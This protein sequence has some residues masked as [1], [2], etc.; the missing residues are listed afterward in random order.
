MDNRSNS[1]DADNRSV[2]GNHI[3]LIDKDASD[4]AT[5]NVTEECATEA[6][7]GRHPSVVVTP[8][9]HRAQQTRVP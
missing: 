3:Y 5:E 8:S 9:E 4:G 1:H 6:H 2:V 7:S